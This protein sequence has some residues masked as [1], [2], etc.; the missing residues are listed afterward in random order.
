MPDIGD[1]GEVEALKSGMAPIMASQD[2]ATWYPGVEFRGEGIF[3]QLNEQAVLD[4]EGQQAIVEMTERHADAQ[5]LWS[6]A[7][8]LSYRPIAARYLL[9]HTLSHAVIRQLSLDCGY[10]S[11]SLR[12]RIYSSTDKDL[13]MAGFMIYTATPDS[14]G[15]LGGLVEMGHPNDLGPLIKNALAEAALCAG[16]PFCASQRPEDDSAELNGAA[17]HACLLIAETACEAGNRHLDRAALVSTLRRSDTAF[18]S[19]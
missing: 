18:V 16:D 15:S 9:L 7:R 5:R 12:E 4:W 8:G 6:E 17:C 19:V 1:L 10:A 13:P 2:T 11:T 14:D 3:I